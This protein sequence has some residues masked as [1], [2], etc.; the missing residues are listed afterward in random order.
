MD[1]DEAPFVI[2]ARKYITITMPT[3]EW[4]RI[5]YVTFIPFII[6]NMVKSLECWW[7]HDMVRNDSFSVPIDQHNWTTYTYGHPILRIC[8][9]H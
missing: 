9:V 6:T 7:A 4:M 5:M 8:S 1:A 3:Q 2:R